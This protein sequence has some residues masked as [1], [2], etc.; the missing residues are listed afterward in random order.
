MK[1]I[2][3]FFE[4]V[5]IIVLHFGGDDSL[6]FEKRKGT[7]PQMHESFWDKNKK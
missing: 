7:Y 2:L 5:I 6:F 3:K 1:N 4:Y